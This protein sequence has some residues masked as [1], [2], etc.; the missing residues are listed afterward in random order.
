MK[1]GRY[2]TIR[3]AFQNYKANKRALENY[4]FPY[5]RG[6]DYSKPRVTPDSTQ[7]GTEQM[8]LSVIDKKSD[9]ER[10]VRLVDET[11][12]WFELEGY[13]R[14][15]YIRLRLIDGHSEVAA[16][17]RIGIADRTGRRWKRDIYEK[18]E[19]IAEKIGIFQSEK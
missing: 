17:M 3:K 16:C 6:V 9:L 10:F 2:A 5:V 7:N 18:A 4:P 15:R 11:V 1:T 19:M 12:K 14:E 8:I 13:G